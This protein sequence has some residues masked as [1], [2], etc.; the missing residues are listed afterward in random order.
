MQSIIYR[1]DGW[2]RFMRGAF[3][4]ICPGRTCAICLWQ[5]VKGYIPTKTPDRES[6]SNG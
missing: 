1:R 3:P 5:R 2:V 4:H 6:G